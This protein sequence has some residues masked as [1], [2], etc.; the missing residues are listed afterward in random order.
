MS[1]VQENLKFAQAVRQRLLNRSETHRRGV[2]DRLPRLQAEYDTK[3]DL[4]TTLGVKEEL[5]E[6]ERA[7]RDITGREAKVS[8]SARPHIGYSDFNPKDPE[9]HGSPD[10]EITLSWEPAGTMGVEFSV[11][12]TITDKDLTIRSKRSDDREG[13]P[14]ERRLRRDE[15]DE[16]NLQRNLIAAYEYFSAP[17]LGLT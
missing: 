3:L 17:M 9:A 16:A 14:F 12:V 2:E 11:A 10:P 7:I 8:I 13:M 6:A 5:T 4:L 15:L 1:A